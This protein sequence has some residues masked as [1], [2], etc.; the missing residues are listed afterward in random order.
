MNICKLSSESFLASAWQEKLVN[1]IGYGRPFMGRNYFTE[2]LFFI[3]EKLLA[4]VK[5]NLIWKQPYV[6]FR[7]AKPQTKHIQSWF[8]SERY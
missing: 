4:N 5:Q 7:Y 8:S 1:G 2:N 3:G 6:V